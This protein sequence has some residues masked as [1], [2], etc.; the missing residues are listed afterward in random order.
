M[1]FSP[2]TIYVTVDT[3]H[4]TLLKPINKDAVIPDAIPIFV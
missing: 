3:E 4:I 1:R 2:T